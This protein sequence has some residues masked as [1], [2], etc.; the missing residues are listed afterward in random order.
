MPPA[1]FEGTESRNASI[2]LHVLHL[3]LQMCVHQL[4]IKASKPLLTQH[5]QCAVLL[6][7]EQSNA[8]VTD[9]IAQ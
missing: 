2:T 4:Y 7:A 3:H 5:M 1:A 9:F 8:S 6:N